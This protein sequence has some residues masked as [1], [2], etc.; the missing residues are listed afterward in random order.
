MIDEYE[1]SHDF[2]LPNACKKCNHPIKDHD[3]EHEEV[4][5][6]FLSYNEYKDYPYGVC[7]ICNELERQAT[8]GARKDVKGNSCMFMIEV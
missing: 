1:T 4:L 3:N 7:L 5:H 8:E 2:E 6:M